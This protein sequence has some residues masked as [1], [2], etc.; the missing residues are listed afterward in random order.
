MADIP[1]PITPV[2]ETTS[3]HMAPTEE[4]VWIKIIEQN[5][6]GV[7]FHSFEEDLYCMLNLKGFK[8]MHE[9]QSIEEADNLRHL[10]YKY[11]EQYKKLP[12]LESKGFDKWAAH[13][14]LREDDLSHEKIAELVKE[15]MEDYASWEAEVLE[16]LL[17]WK[18]SASDRKVVHK[19]IED[20]MKEIKYIE[21]I[22]DVLEEHNYD[23][24][25]ICE[26]SDYLYQVY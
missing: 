5:L 3:T 7:M 24:D 1:T 23:Y 20:V 15:G 22:I 26:M 21:T 8:R 6:E 25:C 16:H 17:E 4:Q 2:V 9:R 19:M 10:K 11:I 18:R 12:I 13:A 14:A